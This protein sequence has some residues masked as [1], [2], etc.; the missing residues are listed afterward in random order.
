MPFCS[1]QANMGR[2]VDQTR[3][4]GVIVRHC[5]VAACARALYPDAPDAELWKSNVV[6]CIEKG[7]PYA[8]DKDNDEKGRAFKGSTFSW[9]RQDCA[10]CMSGANPE[11]I[12]LCDGWN[13]A[14]EAHFHCAGLDAI[15]SGKWFCCEACEAEPGTGSQVA[16]RAPTGDRR[17]RCGACEGCLAEECVERASGAS[18]RR[19]AEARTRSERPVHLRQSSLR[20]TVRRLQGRVPRGARQT[21]ATTHAEEDAVDEPGPGHEGLGAVR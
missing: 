13:C 6:S 1:C 3:D 20:A 10:Y 12:L 8:N 19:S 9:A 4:D 21:A 14:N 17:G 15:P 16:R 11:T 5:S 2:G 7:K 18:T